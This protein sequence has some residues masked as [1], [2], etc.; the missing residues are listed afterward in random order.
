MADRTRQPPSAYLAGLDGIEC[1]TPGWAADWLLRQTNLA[2]QRIALRGVDPI[3]DDWLA[4]LTYTANAWRTS[5][6]PSESGSSLACVPEV[7]RTSSCVGAGVLGTART[8]DLIG[9]T[10]RAVCLAI[11]EG[12]LPARKV[13]GRWLIDI[14]DA[15][16]FRDRRAA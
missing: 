11:S 10:V 9:I 15:R 2:Q 6:S 13:D 8:A 4:A 5:A 1:A 14:E 16:E 12:R 3:V 7:E